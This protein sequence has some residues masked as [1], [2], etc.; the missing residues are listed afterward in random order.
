MVDQPIPQSKSVKIGNYLFIRQNRIFTF[1]FRS[2]NLEKMDNFVPK[3]HIFKS[4]E[5]GE[6]CIKESRWCWTHL[7]SLNKSV[8]KHLN[9]GFCLLNG[10]HFEMAIGFTS[11]GEIFLHDPTLKAIL[12]MTYLDFGRTSP[13][14]FS[15]TNNLPKTFQGAVLPRATDCCKSTPTIPL[16]TSFLWST[17]RWW[18]PLPSVIQCTQSIVMMISTGLAMLRQGHHAFSIPLSFS[19]SYHPEMNES[20]K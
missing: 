2:S 4:W 9:Q 16:Q 3:S 6:S 19:R 11:W 15:R 18:I 14:T 13:I 8:F 12:H 5:D 10:F 7:F 17:R 1:W 20:L